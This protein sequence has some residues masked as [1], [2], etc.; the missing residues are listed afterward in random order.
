MTKKPTPKPR[1][2]WTVIDPAGFYRFTDRCGI[3]ELFTLRHEAVSQNI[4]QLNGDRVIKVTLHYPVNN[5]PR[6]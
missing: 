6:K 4:G 2:F 3:P 1:S 5:F